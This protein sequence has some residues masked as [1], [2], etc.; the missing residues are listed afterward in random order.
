MSDSC[1]EMSRKV[2]ILVI[3]VNYHNEDET[4]CFVQE[5]LAQ[6][7]GFELQVVVVDNNEDCNG[8][9]VLLELARQER[10][11][12]LFQ[13]G[14][15][16][17]YFGG[18]AA[19]L[20]KYLATSPLPEWVI[21]SNTDISFQDAQVL[22]SLVCYYDTDTPTI[23]AVVAPAI[24]STVTGVDQ[25]PFMHRRPSRLRM[26]FYKWVFRFST[27]LIIY[28]LL[29][30]IKECLISKTKTTNSNLANL[31]KHDIKPVRIYAPQGAFIIFDQRY[32]ES[33]GT[34][35][36]GAFLFGEEIF[37]AEMAQHLGLSIVHD[38]RLRVIH[39]EH[40]TTGVFGS[41]KMANHKAQSAAYCAD[42]FF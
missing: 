1:L 33:G 6:K 16:L 4:A 2:T 31:A 11:V 34:L 19:G 10:Q 14:K 7:G 29:S 15:N 24:I 38:R 32:F 35:N 12:S 18:A 36:H 42:T 21:V 8:E 13:P 30:H 23:P 9:A 22:G 25:N 39:G 37:V 17:G 27:S 20:E 41:R 28:E 26:H 40:S 5:L 3:C